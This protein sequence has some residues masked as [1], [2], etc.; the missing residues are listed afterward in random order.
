[1]EGKKRRVRIIDVNSAVER[2]CSAGKPGPE[3][4]VGEKG[5]AAI[6]AAN[7]TAKAA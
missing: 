1:M 6:F 7:F 4:P 5:V 3:Q 2:W